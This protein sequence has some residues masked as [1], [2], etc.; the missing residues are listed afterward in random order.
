MG[1]SV[2]GKVIGPRGEATGII[3][4][5][6]YILPVIFHSKCLCLYPKITAALHLAHREEICFM[7][8]HGYCRDS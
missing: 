4:L 5:N 1:E 3:W 2:C 7:S 6:D 8:G